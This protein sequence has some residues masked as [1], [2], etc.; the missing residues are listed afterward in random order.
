MEGKR[1]GILG[2]ILGSTDSLDDDFQYLGSDH[3]TSPS[4]PSPSTSVSVRNP[5]IS[6]NIRE[7]SNV[8]A[9]KTAET[10]IITDNNTKKA[11][12]ND[13]K[14][15]RNKEIERNRQY[16]EKRTTERRD[17][18]FQRSNAPK[19]SQRGNRSPLN[20]SRSNRYGSRTPPRGYSS[21]YS[22][23]PTKKD[24]P[25]RDRFYTSKPSSTSSSHYT[26]SSKNNN[27]KDYNSL[28]NNNNNNRNYNRDRDNKN[29][30]YNDNKN[31]NKDKSNNNNNDKMNDKDNLKD[32]KKET[33]NI[34]KDN[35]KN[36]IK[37]EGKSEERRI[38]KIK[39]SKN[40]DL[41]KK[42]NNNEVYSE[43]ENMKRIFAYEEV[44]KIIQFCID[45]KKNLK[46]NNNNNNNNNNKLK[47]KM[48]LDDNYNKKN[49]N[50]N[51]YNRK[52][53]ID[54]YK[55]LFAN[56]KRGYYFIKLS[57]EE[58]GKI[59]L[60]KPIE[61][62]S[63]WANSITKSYEKYQLILLFCIVNDQLKGYLKILSF[64]ANFQ[65]IRLK[66]IVKKDFRNF[67]SEISSND[68]KENQ[69]FDGAE[70][71]PLIGEKICELF[72]NDNN[73]AK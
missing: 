6:T 65:K 54:Y 11:P 7:N 70:I 17:E 10:Q 63:S 41:E 24:N 8:K 14:N 12:E 16:E 31:S 9:E 29:N 71:D 67:L 47:D 44:E 49:L 45:N 37:E 22:P 35:I 48:E 55:F 15:T 58:Y 43:L 4:P 73:N 26:S 21:S 39:G 34:N 33:P 3:D 27:N 2:D 28:N 1:D 53:E 19:N 51:N 50:N 72:I 69:I 66:W 18:R 52:K 46:N 20:D 60:E 62:H 32:M 42:N 36:K 61:T 13:N 38:I 30:N 57:Q 56:S 23:Y 64:F 68:L 40:K 5:T 59:L 25:P